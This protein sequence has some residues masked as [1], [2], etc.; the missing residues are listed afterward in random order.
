MTEAQA[1]KIRFRQTKE[2][3]AKKESEKLRAGGKDEIT[4]KPLRKGW[5]LHHNCLD[6]SQYQN[7]QNSF[8]C[9]N[10]MTHKFIHW[11]FV[12]YKKDRS[13]LDRIKQELEEMVRSNEEKNSC[14][15]DV[16]GV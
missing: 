16:L 13:I 1:Q 9:C 8:L 14:R 5:Q 2:W 6:E 11:L 10:N 15:N 7:L 3:K 4:Q 12:Y